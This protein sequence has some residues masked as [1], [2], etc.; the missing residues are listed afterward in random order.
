MADH[1]FEI[2]LASSPEAQQFRH[3]GPN[4]RTPIERTA[5]RLVAIEELECAELNRFFNPTDAYDHGRSAAPGGIINVR[6]R[7]PGAE[8]VGSAGL[9]Y[10]NHGTRE[11]RLNASGPL[12]GQI[13]VSFSG[14]Y[15]DRDGFVTNLPTGQ[16][17]DGRESVRSEERRVGK[18]CRSR[19]SPDH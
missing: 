6:T 16:E 17:I 8:W 14:L 1:A 15:N 7:Q 12:T 4:I 5:Q 3:E 19:W 13:G 9:G 18:E 11:Y 10:G 2:E